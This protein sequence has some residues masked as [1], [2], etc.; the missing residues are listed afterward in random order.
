MARNE[1]WVNVGIRR[2]TAE[3]AV[4]SIRRWWNEMGCF[5]YLNA[6]G[7]LYTLKQPAY[8]TAGCKTGL[9]IPCRISVKREYHHQELAAGLL[10]LER[11]DFEIDCHSLDWIAAD[12]H[13]CF[14]NYSPPPDCPVCRREIENYL[15][16]F[17]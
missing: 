3:F 4:E 12:F 5:N 14:D 11:S 10:N 13:C 9:T 6:T 7:S 2:D 1:G 16:R 15:L 8:L 17:Q